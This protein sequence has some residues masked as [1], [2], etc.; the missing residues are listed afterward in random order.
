MEQI[1]HKSYVVISDG[2]REREEYRRLILR[3][4]L[5]SILCI[6]LI[7]MLFG[8][9][10]SLGSAQISFIEAYSAIFGKF[11]PDYFRTDPLAYTVVWHLRLP[12]TLMA[13]LCGVILAVAGCTTIA[14]LK[15]PLTTPYTLGVSAGAGFGAAIAIILSK[16][17]FEG[18]LIVGNAFV[19][20][21]VPIIVILL[22]SKKANIGP[23]SI[24]LMGVAMSYIFSAC[25][26]LLQ[27]I[28]EA[29]AVR[30]TVFW[31]I[32]DLARASWW[33]I[34]Y[35]T[36]VLVL[37]LFVTMKL[38]PDINIMKMGDEQAKALGVDV[39]RVRRISLLVV[40]LST[41]TVVSFTGAIG[42]ICLLSSH[43]CRLI[44]GGDERY[45]IPI[46]GL[47]GA[48]LL[49]TSD[50]IARRIVAPIMLPVG[51]VTALMGGPLLI[52]LL[53]KR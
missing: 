2:K 41:A 51:A 36:S 14:V 29:E 53:I 13:V 50:I 46:S 52:Y 10:L 18:F 17:L 12:R 20:S 3:R 6:A 16:G 31:L 39:R 28:A 44:V 19:L 38:A 5:F 34:P 47:F 45:L 43:I 25:N 32:G 7:I 37:S 42:F 1:D 11:F 30:M 21:L 9:S 27:F 48:V 22:F 35:A 8:V 26:T 15:N 24:I 23:E 40:C 33:Q 49:L 4:M